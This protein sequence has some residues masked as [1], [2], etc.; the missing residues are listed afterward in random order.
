MGATPARVR[1]LFKSIAT[2]IADTS[3]EV[4][5]Y[6]KAHGEFSSATTSVGCHRWGAR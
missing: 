4:R 5:G 3:K 6:M 2:A 1:Q